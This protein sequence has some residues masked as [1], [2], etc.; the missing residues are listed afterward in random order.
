M[1][2]KNL[3]VKENESFL[4]KIKNWFKGIFGKKDKNKI[5]EP[6]AKLE[7]EKHDDNNNIE[8]DDE[9]PKEVQVKY[10]FSKNI[11][12]KQKIEKVKM[13][14]D[15][16]LIGVAELYQMSDD[17]LEELSQLYDA[18]INDTV[19]KLNELEF[20]IEGYKRKIAKIQAQNQ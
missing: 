10:N 16:G 11:V 12:S 8:Y 3:I 9:Q 13:D 15:K 20:N 6:L 4:A 19:T 14:L 18:Q 7:F 17:E 5:N 1:D 2:N